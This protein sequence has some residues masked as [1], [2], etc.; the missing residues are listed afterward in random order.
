M[1]SCET[2]IT[3]LRADLAAKVAFGC[4]SAYHALRRDGAETERMADRDQSAV[5]QRQG[6]ITRAKDVFR[7]LMDL[8]LMA[9]MITQGMPPRLVAVKRA[10]CEVLGSSEPELLATL[11]EILEQ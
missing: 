7:S 3:A 8:P 5:S 10:F 11:C 1:Y 4:G 9:L 6:D 2:W